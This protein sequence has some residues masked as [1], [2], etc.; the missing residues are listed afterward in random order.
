MKQ[1]IK[2]VL[3]FILIIAFINCGG[4]GG[5]DK[6]VS[7]VILDGDGNTIDQPI[8][9][10]PKEVSDIEVLDMPK[11][12]P[13]KDEEYLRLKTN[14]CLPLKNPSWGFIGFKVP[15]ENVYNL[16]ECT[17]E[18]LVALIDALPIEGGKIV[19]PKCKIEI[20]NG[21]DLP[22]NIILEGAG[23][24]K[25]IISNTLLDVNQSSAIRINERNVILRNFT[26][27]GNGVSLNGVDAYS[28]PNMGNVLVEFIEAKNF[29]SDQGSGISF[30]TRYARYA[31]RVTIRYCVTHN[32]LH[33]INVEVYTDA[34][35]LIY[36]NQSYNNRNYGLD[37]STTYRVEVAGNYIHNNDV[38]GAKSPRGN[39]ITYH[40]NDI[41][42]NKTGGISYM[43]MNWYASITLEEND[44]SN[45]GGLAFNASSAN[46][47]KLILKNNIVTGSI[48]DNGYTIGANGVRFVDVYGDHG[49]IW[50][51]TDSN[52]TY[53]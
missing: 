9:D 17:Q 46:F 19:M 26:I 50:S 8:I 33:G 12:I 31:S 18:A 36:S 38:T 48:D 53:Y 49:K 6:T 22:S 13:C 28:M 4:G 29:K 15:D 21:I 5:S 52:I 35:M 41:N 39:L 2:I 23:I 27:D 24:G 51:G 11:T 16:T 32:S 25:T 3:Y 34:N 7:G 10:T 14:E 43:N 1:I 42:F 37:I 47:R 20:K 30:L 45:N 40:H 44:L